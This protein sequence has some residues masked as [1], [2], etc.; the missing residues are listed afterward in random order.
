MD[1]LALK[2]TGCMRCNI[3]ILYKHNTYTFHLSLWKKVNQFKVNGKT[4][5]QK[6]V[7]FINVM[8]SLPN[9]ILDSFIEI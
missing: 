7:Y 4:F 2:Q 9:I 5:H 3:Y 1:T 8:F 6:F